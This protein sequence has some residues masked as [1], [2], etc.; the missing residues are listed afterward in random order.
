[1]DVKSRGGVRLALLFLTTFRFSQWK[2][3]VLEKSHWIFFAK[4]VG[5]LSEEVPILVPV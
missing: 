4:F 3:F 2:F 1:M 5:S